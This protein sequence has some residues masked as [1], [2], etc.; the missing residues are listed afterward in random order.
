[1]NAI[2][3]TLVSSNIETLSEICKSHLERQLL[4]EDGCTDCD[5]FISGNVIKL[6]EQWKTEED[7]EYHK[8]TENLKLFKTLIEPFVESLHI[9]C[10]KVA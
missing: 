8:T 7:Y 5:M 3:A 6:I 10:F 1:M 9:E 4:L 2:I